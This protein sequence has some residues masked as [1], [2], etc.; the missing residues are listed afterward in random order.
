MVSFWNHHHHHLWREREK[1]VMLMLYTGS[2]ASEKL[3]GTR[4]S[5][6][7]ELNHP[8][9]FRPAVIYKDVRRCAIFSWRGLFYFLLSPISFST[10]AQQATTTTTSTALKWT[11]V[12][13]ERHHGEK[14]QTGR[15][16]VGRQGC[17]TNRQNEN[18]QK[19]ES[20][21]PIMELRELARWITPQLPSSSRPR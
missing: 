2:S 5:D 14:K 20:T 1:K 3:G 9:S 6:T 10:L 16:P 8:V 17:M 11:A 7:T 18:K 19:T 4:P 15:K 12:P 13:I 21:L